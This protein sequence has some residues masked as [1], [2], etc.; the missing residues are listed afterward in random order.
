MLLALSTE[1]IVGTATAIGL[2]IGGLGM[3]AVEWGRAYRAMRAD[4]RKRN[5]DIDFEKK[6]NDIELHDKEVSLDE[7]HHYRYIDMLQ[8]EIATLRDRV[9]TVQ[10]AS[11]RQIL[12][13]ER[14]R[15]KCDQALSSANTKIAFQ[16]QTIK[17][18]S[19]RITHQETKIKQLEDR[20][21]ALEEGGS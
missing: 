12:E 20:L 15:S 8:R 6:K 21:V 17:E 2:V 5:N 19:L 9:S 14:E 11:L 13:A 4:A 18:Q 10:D 16:E 3:K 1:W 7:E